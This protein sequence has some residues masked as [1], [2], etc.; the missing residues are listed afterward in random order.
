[1]VIAA[2]DHWIRRLAVD[3][4]VSDVELIPRIQRMGQERR[5]ADIRATGIFW[6]NAEV[7]RQ[8]HRRHR[9][10]GGGGKDAIH[11]VQRDIGIRQSLQHRFGH[12]FGG[13]A[14][15]RLATA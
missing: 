3:Q 14:P 1:M 9:M 11:L 5:A 15:R 8:R 13:V 12:Q 6:V 4:S 2:F 10:N 7:F